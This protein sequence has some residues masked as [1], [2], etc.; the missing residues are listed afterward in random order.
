M[1]VL[2]ARTRPGGR[3]ATEPVADLAQP[4][5]LGAEFIH[6]E[7]PLTF[8][9]AKEAGL[10]IFPVDPMHLCP[11]PEERLVDCAPRF[12]R[13]H[14]H[15]VAGVTRDEAF[16]SWLARQPLATGDRAAA[17]AYVEGFYAAH[18]D[19]ASAEA[20]AQAEAAI[21]RGGG[22]QN[23]RLEAG[24]A[25]LVDWLAAGLPIELDTPVDM[26]RWH[27][28]GVEA[29]AGSRRFVA[30]RAIVALPL[31]A[32][33][34]A[35]PSFAPP[36]PHHADLQALEMGD[37]V[38]LVLRFRSAEALRR[39]VSPKRFVGGEL[40]PA[41]FV[42]LPEADLPTWWTAWKEPTPLLVGWAG[43]EAASRLRPDVAR[44]PE[45]VAVAG[46]AALLGAA[47][48]AVRAA[49]A[50]VHFHD[51]SADPFSGGAYSWHGVGGLQAQQRAA[52]PV[53]DTLFFAGEWTDAE[54]IGTV[55]AALRSGEAA[56]ERL[57]RAAAMPES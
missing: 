23:F 56:A 47:P 40:L 52:M 24:Y 38:K 2:E 19:R 7:Q 6:G 46:A 15:L 17:I 45:A 51:W 16:S 8:A 22:E 32:L 26:I 3:I 36:L 4:V 29:L 12:Q 9:L 57:V 50:S 31:E 43:G 5:E 41:C 13:V 27:A 14:Q 44:D 48:D 35:R 55:E 28:G 34:R 21:D 53:A 42:H 1:R 54:D 37:V 25:A 10:S 18:V 39:L 11:D 30:R 49:L 20:I 33:R